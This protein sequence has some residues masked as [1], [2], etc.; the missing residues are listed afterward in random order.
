MS[1]KALRKDG[2]NESFLHGRVT[3][4]RQ[5]RSNLD[6]PFANVFRYEDGL[7]RDYLI[8]VDNSAL[9]ASGQV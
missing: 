6:V 1:L 8:F 3:Y 9:F 5:D 7:I 4:T 2:D